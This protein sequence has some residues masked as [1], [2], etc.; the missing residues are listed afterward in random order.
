MFLIRRL[1]L[2]HLLA[3]F[4]FQTDYIY[5]IKTRGWAGLIIHGLVFA[6][7]SFVLC[8]PVIADVFWPVLLITVFHVVVDWS[9][10]HLISK[11]KIGY[12]L[13]FLLDQAM[14]IGVI[15]LLIPLGIADKVQYYWERWLSGGWEWFNI[16]KYDQPLVIISGFIITMFAGVIL[17]NCIESDLHPGRK[18]ILEAPFRRYYGMFERG[19][20]LA[21]ALWSSMWVVPLVFLPR[22]IWWAG[23]GRRNGKDM[24]IIQIEDI[25]V[26]LILT[27]FSFYIIRLLN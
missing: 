8:A 12:T 10:I 17:I 1:I 22:I 5:R 4:A 27:V 14:H 6:L 25:V 23:I 15:L 19:A 13:S 9:K 24:G 2:A 11:L 16:L 20:L 7:S 18:K 3:D 21:A 26:N